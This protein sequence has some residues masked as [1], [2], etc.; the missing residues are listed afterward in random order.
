FNNLLV[1][2]Y[3]LTASAPGFATAGLNDV[4]VE[5]NR[6]TTANVTLSVRG[7]AT[8]V[9][10]TDA[11]SL[12][13]TTTAQVT[14][15]YFRE[16]VEDLPL[17][18]NPQATSVYNLSLTGAGIASSG[19]IGVGYGPSVGGQRPRNNNFMVEGAD[20]NLKD[21]TGPNVDIPIDAIKEFSVLQNQFSPEFGHSSG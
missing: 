6:T 7:A 5:L 21:V 17:A 12:I 9:N 15:T 3:R 2:R 16:M 20:N 8:E 13:D 14:N 18:A 1:G 4:Q 10:V 11:I 19:G